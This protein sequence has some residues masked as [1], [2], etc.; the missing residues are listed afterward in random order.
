MFFRMLD[1]KSVPS[2]WLYE[3][4]TSNGTFNTSSFSICKQPFFRVFS[5]KSLLNF[6]FF[7]KMFVIPSFNR[8]QVNL[9]LLFP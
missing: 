3:E 4:L 9:F 2:S 6:Q 8:F 7:E 5:D 1:Y